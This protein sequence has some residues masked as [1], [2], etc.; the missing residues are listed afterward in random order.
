MTVLQETNLFTGATSMRI[1]VDDS[2]GI[3]AHSAFEQ[4]ML[5]LNP[6]KHEALKAQEVT[7]ARRCVK[8][9]ESRLEKIKQSMLQ[10]QQQQQQSVYA[11]NGGNCVPTYRDTLQNALSQR[12]I[13]YIWHLFMFPCGN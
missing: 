4:L 9:I 2:T 11:S 8:K 10:Q 7:A 3:I 5:A 12:C 1:A 6:S 13:I